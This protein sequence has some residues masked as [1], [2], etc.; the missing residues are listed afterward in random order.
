MSTWKIRLYH[1]LPYTLRT[2]AASLRGWQLR[3]WRYGPE[4]EVMAAEALSRECWSAQQWKRWQEERLVSLLHRAATKVPYYRE[5]WAERRRK[6]DGRSWEVLEH[7]PVL[8]KEELRRNPKAFIADDCNPRKLF[9]DHTSGTTGKPVNLYCSRESVRAWYALFEARC[10]MWNGVTRR[11][12]WGI[13][14]GQLVAPVSQRRPPFWVWNDGLNQLYLSAYHLAPDLI[15]H[16]LEALN[17][18]EV[19]YLLGY[20]SALHAL[21]Q[22][23][24]ELRYSV[25]PMRVVITNAEPVFPHQR[26]IIQQ[27]F[28]CPV[29]ETYGMAEMVA[30]GSE[31]Q[32]GVLHA[33]PEAGWMELLHEE[34]KG[35]LKTGELVC[36]SLL[37]ANMPLVRYRVG[38]RISMPIEQETCAC[39]RTLPILSSIEGRVDDVLYTQDGRSVGRLDPVFKAGLPIREAQIVQETLSRIR[40]TYVPTPQFR[41][42][43][44]E[45]IV[46]RIR[47]RLGLVE[48]VLEP[49][50]AVPRTS[51][52][53]LRAVVCQLSV[54][55]RAKVGRQRVKAD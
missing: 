37:N 23:A 52:G 12:R 40:V 35:G 26:K 16:Y 15:Q 31:C 1:S 36:T 27:A 45:N 54:E 51:G 33:H 28:G 4:T 2:T 39:G 21:A 34:T 24:L 29:R 3:F 50:T 48:V 18:Y 44:G 53:K 17:R 19:T 46:S 20:T 11:D 7:W 38:D 13:L 8:E 41:A 42:N 55:E 9:V 6:G 25:P 32:A 10:R 47:E 49:V 30:A 22:G 43:D 14:G 5:H